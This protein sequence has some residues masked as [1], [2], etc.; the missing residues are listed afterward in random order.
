MRVAC[1][2]HGRNDID[3]TRSSKVAYTGAFL[4]PL[5]IC[6]VIVTVLSVWNI[7]RLRT[8]VMGSGAAPTRVKVI[9]SLV[10]SL[11]LYPLIFLVA[12]LPGTLYVL[13]FVSFNRQNVVLEYLTGVGVSSTGTIFALAYLAQFYS[14]QIWKS[15]DARSGLSTDSDRWHQQQMTSN[16]VSGMWGESEADEDDPPSSDRNASVSVSSST[17]SFQ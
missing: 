1:N 7:Y 10:R 3:V 12:F 14:L 13:I 2:L 5:A 6:V 11:R 8:A 4:F 16:T 17:A 15:K 9:F